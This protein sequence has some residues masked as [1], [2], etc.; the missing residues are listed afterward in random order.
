MKTIAWS[1]LLMLSAISVSHAFSLSSVSCS[2]NVASLSVSD[3]TI[4]NTVSASVSQSGSGSWIALGSIEAG[5]TS[6]VF[7]LLM[8]GVD[9]I[10]DYQT[11]SYRVTS[12][13][14]SATGTCP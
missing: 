14:L 10:T 13:D 9:G 3:I 7:P 11:A 8:E 5:S 1:T 4:G 12:G 2:D 6:M